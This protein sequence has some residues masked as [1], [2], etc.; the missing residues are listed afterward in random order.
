MKLKFFFFGALTFLLIHM[1]SQAAT[2][3]Q[4]C[5][6]IG[7]DTTPFFTHCISS[8]FTKIERATGLDLASC[9]NVSTGYSYSY[10]I[11]ARKNFRHVADRL[12]LKLDTCPTI[13][14]ELNPF[15]ITC[16]QKNFKTIERALP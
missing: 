5:S 6:W 3:L 1:A 7:N 13:G 4:R 11:C 8:N 9:Y 16:V 2:T 10:Q 14:E 12:K 15:Y